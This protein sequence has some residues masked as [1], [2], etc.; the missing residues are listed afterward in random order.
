MVCFKK[1]KSSRCVNADSFTRTGL[2]NDMDCYMGPP[3]PRFT[4]QKV[5]TL[6]N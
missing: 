3:S 6:R 2:H 4:L 5:G 1:N